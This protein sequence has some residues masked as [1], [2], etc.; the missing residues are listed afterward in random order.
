MD[1][2]AAQPAK[3]RNADQ[4]IAVAMARAHDDSGLECVGPPGWF[5]TIHVV[6]RH[7]GLVAAIVLFP[8]NVP[9]ATIFVASYLLRTWGMEAVYHRYF[10]HRSYRAGRGFQM[11][12]A[13]VGTQ[14]GQRGPLWWAYVHRLHHR[15]ADTD[16]D[17]HSPNAHSFWHAYMGWMRNTESYRMD[18]GEIA[19]F[20]RFPE[21]RWLT[22]YYEIPL[23]LGGV[24]L[25]VAGHFG[26][27]GPGVSGWSAYLWG[28]CAPAALV[29]HAVALLNTLGH[30]PAL[31]GG[32]RNF[33]DEPYATN[34]PI[35]S[36]L[37]LGAGLHNNH[38]QSAAS[39]RTAVAWHEMDATF[40]TLQWLRAAGLVTHLRDAR[41]GACEPRVLAASPRQ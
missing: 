41:I 12:L 25:F 6:L 19:D 21:L 39:A 29:L 33:A 23:E 34:R 26:V 17:V 38:H 8:L 37:M 35:L 40:R 5:S 31:L 30:R 36:L 28:Y 11:V 4:P 22:R 14:C 9:L 20:A 16:E 13:L 15:Y 7:A 27:F 2:Q 32:Y 24:A 10:S 3:T 18:F 1:D